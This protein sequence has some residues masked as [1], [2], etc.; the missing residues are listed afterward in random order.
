MELT[1][2]GLGCFR[3]SE[4]GYPA[5]V[6]DPFDEEIVGL[7]GCHARA[8]LVTS[9]SPMEEPEKARWKGVRGP[10]RTIAGPGEYEIGGLFINGI[11]TFRDRKKG[12]EAGQN[13]VYTFELNGVVICHLGELGHVPNQ[14]QV[15][16]IGP[17]HVL[18]L[19]V[20]IP[21]GLTP[22]QCS[23]VISLLEPNVIIPMHYKHPKLEVKLEGVDRFLK[24]V[25]ATPTGEPVTSVKFTVSTIPQEPQVILMEPLQ[26]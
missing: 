15:E 12:A 11:D 9:S 8:D 23:E 3:L 17:I 2:Y 20:G 25:G 4:R 1:W 18:L 16:A 19:P 22:T 5:V 21:H 7:S 24:E 14:T 10:Y 6:T 26:E 13:V